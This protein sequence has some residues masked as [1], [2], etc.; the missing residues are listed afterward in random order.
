V[1]KKHNEISNK[2]HFQLQ[3]KPE[4]IFNRVKKVTPNNKKEI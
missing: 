3:M 2:A 4:N 1:E